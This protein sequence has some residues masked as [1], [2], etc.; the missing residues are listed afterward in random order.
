MAF[1]TSFPTVYF[2]ELLYFKCFIDILKKNF[3]LVEFLIA[4]PFLYISF[5]VTNFIISFFNLAPIAFDLS[6]YFN[7]VVILLMALIFSTLVQGYLKVKNQ[8]IYKDL[9]NVKLKNENLKKDL[10]MMTNYINPHF[11][12]NSLNSLAGL[13]SENPVKAENVVLTL[14]QLYRGILLAL[15]KEFHSVEEELRICDDYLE[16][17]K[18]RFDFRLLIVKNIEISNNDLMKIQIP[19]LLLQ[20]LFENVIKHGVMNNLNVTN[21]LFHLC[22][23]KEMLVMSICNNVS[24]HSKTTGTESTLVILRDRLKL[25]YQDQAS[26]VINKT[27]SQFEVILKLPLTNF[28]TLN[29]AY[30]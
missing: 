30:V 19:T 9:E 5:Y 2:S 14:S 17:E 28:R 11:L 24:A 25:I 12:F 22:I 7:G 29:N 4:L 21:C 18:Y 15:K 20:P 1:F 10:K 26:M 27:I 8:A 6:I 13:I 3:Y 16:I 23:E